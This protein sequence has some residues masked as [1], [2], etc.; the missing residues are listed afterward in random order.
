M[1]LRPYGFVINRNDLTNGTN[2]RAYAFK[3]AK[4]KTTSTYWCI[5]LYCLYLSCKKFYREA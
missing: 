4:M 1:P 5:Q 3:G 2:A